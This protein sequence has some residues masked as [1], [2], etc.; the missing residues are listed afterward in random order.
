M[1][2]RVDVRT[3]KVPLLDEVEKVVL[4]LIVDEVQA[5]QVLV[6]RTVPEVIDDENILVPA[7]VERVDEIAADKAGTAC[8]DNHPFAPS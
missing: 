1:E 2:D 4:L 6:V 3:V 8:D 5:A 7:C